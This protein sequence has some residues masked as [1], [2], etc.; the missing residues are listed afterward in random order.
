M[1]QVAAQLGSTRL[2]LLL[3][4]PLANFH[5][6]SVDRTHTVL[7]VFLTYLAL[8]FMLMF[9]CAEHQ[10]P[11]ANGSRSGSGSGLGPNAEFRIIPGQVRQ[12]SVWL[13]NLCFLCVANIFLYF[14]VKVFLR[15]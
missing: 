1:R 12:E 2:L 13:E 4:T 14:F 6:S 8:I 9:L 5:S 7:G 10:K 15:V 11:N 3:P